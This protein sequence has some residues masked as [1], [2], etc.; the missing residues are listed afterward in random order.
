MLTP[1]A[2]LLLRLDSVAGLC[3]GVVVLLLTPWLAT[4]YAMP[5]PWVRGMGL[6]NLAYGAASGVLAWRAVRGLDVS[7][8]AVTTLGLANVSWAAVCLVLAGVFV[9]DASSVGVAMLLAEALFVGGLGV[10]EW[11]WA[12]PAG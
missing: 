6:A 8:R 4:L 10:A 3:V 2:R 1:P 9:G 5:E 12:R 11:R 7:R